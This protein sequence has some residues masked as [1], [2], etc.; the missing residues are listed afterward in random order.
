MDGTHE[1]QLAKL[2]AKVNAGI[3]LTDVENNLKARLEEKLGADK[4]KP[5]AKIKTKKAV[6]G[7]G[8]F[9]EDDEVE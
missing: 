4:P 7:T 6:S 3:E 8:K 5:K 2:N 9:P 1:E